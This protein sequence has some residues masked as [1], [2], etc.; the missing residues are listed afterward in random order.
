[1]DYPLKVDVEPVS[2]DSAQARAVLRA[3]FRDI[4]SRQHGREATTRE[5]VAAMKAEPSDNLR[6]PRGV[7][8]VARS[9]DDGVVVGCAGLRLITAEI[10][11]VTRVFVLPEARRRGVGQLLMEAVEDAARAQKLVTLRLD[12]GRHLSEARQLYLK[13]GFR[14]VPAFN[15]GRLADQWYEKPLN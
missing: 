13:S 9:A 12:T 2:P 11:E 6:P 1:M 7:L 8:F 5:I 10:G 4:M 14:E 15:E 3:Y